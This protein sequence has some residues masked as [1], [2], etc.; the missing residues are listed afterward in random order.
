MT[1]RKAFTLIELLIVVVIIGILAAIA[2]P[3]FANTKE[4]AVVASMKSDLSGL[5][6]AQASFFS[7]NQDYAGGTD[8]TA[9]T[10]GKAGAGKVAFSPSSGNVIAVKYG[11]AAGWSATVT[12]PAVKSTAS[13]E[14]GIY[15]G[16]AAAP[17]ASLT[18][19]GAPGCY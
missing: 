13:D 8:P 4:K 9:Q 12:N 17:D 2:I 18:I 14:C 5:V 19:E 15:V 1:G 3:K 6:T 11:S 10:K 16:T 7:H